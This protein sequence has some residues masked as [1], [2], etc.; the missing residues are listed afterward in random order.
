MKQKLPV[1]DPP[2]DNFIELSTVV[3]GTLLN[4]KRLW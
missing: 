1:L 4:T 3:L 2:I